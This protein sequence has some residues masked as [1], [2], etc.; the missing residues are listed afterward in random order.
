MD[1]LAAHKS[2]GQRLV[3]RRAKTGLEATQLAHCSLS[4]LTAGAIKSPINRVRSARPRYG[5]YS[6]I[7][8]PM[9][10]E[11]QGVDGPGIDS[12]LNLQVKSM[13]LQ[14]VNELQIKVLRP[15]ID[16]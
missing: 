10:S 13:S 1:A 6:T 14:M 2:N 15:R 12:L 9:Q 5:L 16:S 11:P 7:S 4:S 3:I 8:T